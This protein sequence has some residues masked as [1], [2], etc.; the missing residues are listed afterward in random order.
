MIP[1]VD[2]PS[3]K[4]M[5]LGQLVALG[6]IIEFSEIKTEE[7]TEKD[8]DKFED[9]LSWILDLRKGQ[10]A[11]LK[12]E[13][14]EKVVIA[15]KNVSVECWFQYVKISA[16]KNNIQLFECEP[17]SRQE[18]EEIEIEVKYKKKGALTRLRA[19]K[20]KS[21]FVIPDNLSQ[22][23]T[24]VWLKFL[25]NLLKR[26]EAID[27]K[28]FWKYFQLIPEIM[29]CVAWKKDESYY[30]KSIEGKTVFNMQRVKEHE[31]IFLQMRATDAIRSFAFFLT[32]AKPYLKN[33]NSQSLK[34]A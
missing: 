18:R 23:P 16:N 27:S 28:E 17:V 21:I 11:L 9:S 25:D 26:Y 29:S 34:S 31:N 15:I 12:Q 13:T 32:I 30:T 8:L 1:T 19:A 3:L 24:R 10:V 6:N 14:I 20:K 2:I 7:R 5:S 4:D 33:H 22:L